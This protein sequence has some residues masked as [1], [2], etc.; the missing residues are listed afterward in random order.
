[1]LDILRFKVLLG[2]AVINKDC[3]SAKGHTPEY[4]ILYV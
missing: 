1:M 3:L 4:N 2:I